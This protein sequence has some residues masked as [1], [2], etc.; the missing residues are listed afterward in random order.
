MLISDKYKTVVMGLSAGGMEALETIL[1]MLRK[2]CELS[3][4]IVIHRGKD[5]DGFFIRHMDSISKL[6]VI[7]ARDK[8]DIEP[9]LEKSILPLQDIT[10][11]WN[12]IKLSLS[13]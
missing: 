2:G 7:E 12:R 6:K 9:G 1:P 5:Q 3:C 4:I 10:C 8:M 11:L 13:L